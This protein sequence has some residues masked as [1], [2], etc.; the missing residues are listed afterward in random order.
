MAEEVLIPPSGKITSVSPDR[1]A[2]NRMAF[3]TSFGSSMLYGY[4]LAVV[5]SPAVYIKDFYNKTV[6]GRNGTGLS[7]ETLTL[8]YSLTV[9]VFAVGGLL[10]SLIVGMLVT[11]YDST[12]ELERFPWPCAEHLHWNWSFCCPNPRSTRASRKGSQTTC[13]RTGL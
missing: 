3:L 6:V 5:N 1:R 11:R 7:E 4:N 13:V 2:L 10:G 8:M 9:S 12:K